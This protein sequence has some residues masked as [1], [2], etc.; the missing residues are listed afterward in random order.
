MSKHLL[1]TLEHLHYAIKFSKQTF[2]LALLDK[3]LSYLL[4]DLCLLKTAKIR[5]IIVAK[6]EDILPKKTALEH[7]GFSIQN[8]QSLSCNLNLLEGFGK[9]VILMLQS[10]ESTQAQDLEDLAF[11]V[12]ID[13]KA[14]KVFL[15]SDSLSQLKRNNK[16][17]FCISTQQLSQALQNNVKFNVPPQ[18][19]Q[20]WLKKIRQHQ[21]EIT[22]LNAVEGELFKEVFTHLGSGS[23]IASQYQNIIRK[24]SNADVMEVWFLLKHYVN[25]YLLLPV[26][27]WELIANIQKYFVHQVNRSIISCATLYDYENMAELRSFCITEKHQNQGYAQQLAKNMLQQAKLQNKEAIFA[28]SMQPNVW[29]FF[30]RLGFQNI[31]RDLLPASWQKHYDFGR[32]SKAFI[33]YF[34]TNSASNAPP[35]KLAGS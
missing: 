19:L 18:K 6:A 16:P 13:C 26:S 22:L 24:A 35:E 20:Y 8:V 29:E 14:I 25:A 30:L 23:L 15:F 28:L 27:E 34:A 10:A 5:T 7:L 12:A 11:K 9:P 21:F 3:Q 1:Q 4:T 33:Y 31:S 17:I 32:P 2:V